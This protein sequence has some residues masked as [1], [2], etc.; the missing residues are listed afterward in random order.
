ML[1]RRRVYGT[2][3]VIIAATLVG[4]GLASAHGG[5]TSLIHSCVNAGGRIR[6]VEATSSCSAQEQPLDWNKQGPPGPSL[7]SVVLRES[8]R[9]LTL[10]PGERDFV[11]SQCVDGEVVISGGAL[12][13]PEV[14]TVGRSSLF[15]DGTHSGWSVRFDNNTGETLTFTPS[16][17]AE[18]VPG[19]MSTG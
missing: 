17:G 15:F 9:L 3:L 16:V 8:S 4:S 1:I 5:D 12:N 10:A 18:C 11:S 14:V 19:S 2:A 6:I 7:L 13:A